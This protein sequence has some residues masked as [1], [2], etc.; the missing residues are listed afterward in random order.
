MLPLRCAGLTS[1]PTFVASRSTVLGALA[2]RLAPAKLSAQLAARAVGSH[3][4]AQAPGLGQ[5]EGMLTLCS[6]LPLACTLTYV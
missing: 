3:P 6:P 2:E 1:K 5:R 4:T